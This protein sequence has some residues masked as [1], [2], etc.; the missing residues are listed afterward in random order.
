MK[1]FIV[2]PFPVLCYFPTFRQGHPRG[3]QVRP[4]IWSAAF[5]GEKSIL[6]IEKNVSIINQQMLKYFFFKI[7]LLY[8]MLYGDK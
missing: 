7:I 3:G 2:S 4:S 6:T 5:G 1:G 8:W